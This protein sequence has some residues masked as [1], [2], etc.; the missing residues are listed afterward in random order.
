MNVRASLAVVALTAGA[1][2]ATAP[3]ASAGDFECRG[4]LGAVTVVGS[5]IVPD[6]ATCTLDGTSVRAVSS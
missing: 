4:T 1:G 2:L 6:D 5:V 3:A